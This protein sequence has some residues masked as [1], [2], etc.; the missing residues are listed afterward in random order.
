MKNFA[1]SCLAVTTIFAGCGGSGGSSSEDQGPPAECPEVGTQPAQECLAIGGGEFS[2]S[3]NGAFGFKVVFPSEQISKKDYAN[4]AV[5]VFDKN[6]CASAM[7]AQGDSTFFPWMDKMDHGLGDK[8]APK[9][10]T[11]RDE[12]CKNVFKVSKIFYPMGQTWQFYIKPKIER[13]S[14]DIGVIS[15]FVKKQK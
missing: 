14:D 3:K 10:R 7:A 1:L 15:H 12:N 9:V 2:K 4:D 6:Q 8:Y 13:G 11:V 5:V